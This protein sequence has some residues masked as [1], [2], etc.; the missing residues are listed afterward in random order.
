MSSI[1][2]P[3]CALDAVP[4][5]LARAI[6]V[7]LVAGRVLRTDGARFVVTAEIVAVPRTHDRD[8][9]VRQAT[10]ALQAVFERWIRESA[11]AMDVGSSALGALTPPSRRQISPHCRLHGSDFQPDCIAI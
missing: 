1:L 4:A 8:A 6:G 7:P 3:A 5:L 11:G 9:D 10:E 2:R